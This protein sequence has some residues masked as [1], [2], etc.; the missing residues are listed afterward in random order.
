MKQPILLIIFGLF[1]ILQTQAQTQD[2]IS[3][4]K[5]DRIG[6]VVIKQNRLKEKLKESPLTV[7]SMGAQ[8]IRETP[9]SDFYEAL[10]HLK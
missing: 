3:P 10:G 2:S 4:K 8:S 6:E 7:E 5:V 1:S 9:A